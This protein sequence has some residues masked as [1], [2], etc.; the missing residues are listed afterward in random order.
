MRRNWC[1]SC[2]SLG[3][4]H[5]HQNSNAG[6]VWNTDKVH[7]YFSDL[8]NCWTLETIEHSILRKVE[9]RAIREGR[10]DRNSIMNLTIPAGL[11][12][13]P[14]EIQDNGL[15][16]ASA[17]SDWDMEYVRNFYPQTNE[18]VPIKLDPFVSFKLDVE[19]GKQIDLNVSVPRDREYTIETIG[20]A[21]A[22]LT[23]YEKGK[24]GALTFIASDDDSGSSRN[25]KVHVRL[26]AKRP[27]VVRCRLV[28]AA[29]RG[30]VALIIY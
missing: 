10:W 17:I 27:Y 21:D 8:P 18:L 25:A 13:H 12:L 1:T 20:K 30:E 5:E 9:P 14:K 3:M 6:V 15:V 11:A 7:K 23:M 28:Y 2:S 16:A 22:F 19:N 4:E 24:S 26:L 29:S